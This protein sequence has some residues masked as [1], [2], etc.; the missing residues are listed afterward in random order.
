MGRKKYKVIETVD[1]TKPKSFLD[2]KADNFRLL[3]SVQDAYLDMDEDLYRLN[4]IYTKNVEKNFQMFGIVDLNYQI[5]PF[6]ESIW[7]PE[8]IKSKPKSNE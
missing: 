7:N 8:A 6:L 1:P 4:R 5:D 3:H 2:I